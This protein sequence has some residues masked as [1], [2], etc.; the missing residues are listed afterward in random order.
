MLNKY[1]IDKQIGKDDISHWTVSIMIR[2]L[3]YIGDCHCPII[4]YNFW[5]SVYRDDYRIAD[6]GK[7]RNTQIASK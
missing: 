5:M 4:W 3:I 7:C 6:V 2:M 1:L